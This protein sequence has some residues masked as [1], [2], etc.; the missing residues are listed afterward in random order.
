VTATVPDRQLGAAGCVASAAFGG[1]PC[2]GAT[3]GGSSGTATARV[4]G[5]R[6]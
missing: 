5:Y 4:A 1:V 3:A 2:V 6:K